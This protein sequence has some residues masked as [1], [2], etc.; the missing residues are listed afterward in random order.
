MTK[1]SDR[2]KKVSG[3]LRK[4]GIKPFTKAW[5]K[6]FKKEYKKQFK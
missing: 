1:Q 3:I 4:K 5:G 6:A 2:L